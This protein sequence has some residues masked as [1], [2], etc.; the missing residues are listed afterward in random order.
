MKIEEKEREEA[1]KNELTGICSV[2]GNSLAIVPARSHEFVIL[3][4]DRKSSIQKYP[5]VVPEY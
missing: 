3:T 2:I 1:E 5:H 4:R